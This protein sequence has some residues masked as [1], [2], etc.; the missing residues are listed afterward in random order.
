MTGNVGLMS[1]DIGSMNQ[2]V[3]RP[4]SFMNSVMPW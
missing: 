3:G 1:R 4:M 2:N